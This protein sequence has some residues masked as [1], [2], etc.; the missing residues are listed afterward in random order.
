MGS[1]ARLKSADET[2]PLNG[3]AAGGGYATVGDFN[4]F[5]DGL[6]CRKLLV[7]F[8][9]NRGRIRR[10]SAGLIRSCKPFYAR[11]VLLHARPGNY[12]RDMDSIS[13]RIQSSRF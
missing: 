5:V 4:R 9:P 6:T 11:R 2:L 10:S 12:A 13:A 3:T 7:G 1:G 8:L